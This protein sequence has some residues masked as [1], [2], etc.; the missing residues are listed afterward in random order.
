MEF[1]QDTIN[2][3]TITT[4][5]A[6]IITTIAT[7]TVII[8]TTITINNNNNNSHYHNNKR[9]FTILQSNS[10]FHDL[11]I[12]QYFYLSNS[13][14]QQKLFLFNGK[15]TVV[16]HKRNNTSVTQHIKRVSSEKKV[17]ILEPKNF[18][19]L[20]TSYFCHNSVLS[21]RIGFLQ[22][23]FMRRILFHYICMQQF[24]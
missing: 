7:S 22:D 23:C 12:F 21:L 1:T 5:I 19:I 9:C 24:A 15:G 4:I 18:L 3:T 16:Y 10:G 2:I 11:K 17:S 14:E 8:A 6:T 13:L 20:K